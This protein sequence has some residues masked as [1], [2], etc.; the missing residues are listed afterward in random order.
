[1]SEGAGRRAVDEALKARYPRGELVT[2]GKGVGVLAEIRTYLHPA[3]E[4]DPEHWHYVTLGLSELDEKTSKDLEESGWGIELTMRVEAPNGEIDLPEWPVLALAKLAAYVD[5]TGR[6]L[7]DGDKVSLEG[8]VDPAAPSIK[9][10]AMGKDLELGTIDTPHGRL[11]F[12]Q[13]VGVMADEADLI[14][15]WSGKGF[16]DALA[17]QTPLLLTQP[18]RRSLLRDPMIGPML[19]EQALSEGSSEGVVLIDTLVWQISGWSRKK[20]RVSLGPADMTRTNLPSLL[21]S[22][23]LRGRDLRIVSGERTLKLRAGENADW[24]EEDGRLVLTM[25]PALIA[26]LD[27]FLKK[28]QPSLESQA[29][30][31]FVLALVE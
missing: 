27:A 6:V 23:T 4:K 17:K 3:T 29:L 11:T 24:R 10:L 2:F 31:G 13:A 7:Q 30:P 1:M 19:R 8:A 18:E 9:G 26:E 21:A 12:L 22:R 25:S 15:R 16:L 14:T 28:D 5:E 20:V